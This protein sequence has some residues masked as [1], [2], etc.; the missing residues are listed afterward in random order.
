MTESTLGNKLVDLIIDNNLNVN[1]HRFIFAFLYGYFIMFGAEHFIHST[2]GIAYYC[3]SLAVM[4]YCLFH[5]SKC[6]KFL[7]VAYILTAVLVGLALYEPKIIEAI[8]SSIIL[9]AEVFFFIVG[10]IIAI[11]FSIGVLKSDDSQ[12]VEKMHRESEERRER[13]NQMWWEEHYEKQRKERWERGQ[14]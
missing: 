4:P 12:F 6:Y 1:I 9:I 7:N 13:E 10:A 14:L 3:T 11:Y 5:I 8:T 2:F